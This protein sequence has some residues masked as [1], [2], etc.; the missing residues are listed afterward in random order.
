MR[1]MVRRYPILRVSSDYFQRVASERMLRW[2]YRSR[3]QSLIAVSNSQFYDGKLFIVP[4]PFTQEA[5]MG[6]RFHH[7]SDGMFEDGVNK[8][9]AKVVAEAIIRHAL[10]TPERSLGVAAFS[11]KQRVKSRTNWSY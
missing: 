8:V 2:H 6:L 7:V 3:H 1:M 10:E 11:I 9:E 4:S 5:G